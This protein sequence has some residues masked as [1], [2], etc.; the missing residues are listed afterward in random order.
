MDNLFVGAISCGEVTKSCDK[1][2][3][4]EFLSDSYA[5][6]HITCMKNNLTY[7]KECYIDV[8]IVNGQKMKCELKGTV[9]TN[10]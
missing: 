5:S 4:E 8:M 2:E 7:V 6:S 9:N 1:K 10:I 3:T